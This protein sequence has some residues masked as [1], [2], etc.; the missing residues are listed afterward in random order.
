MA[1]VSHGKYL[2]CVKEL[3]KTLME[4]PLIR[5]LGVDE[6]LPG[7]LVSVRFLDRSF[8]SGVKFWLSFPSRF[9]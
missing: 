6:D 4:L 8:Q 3:Y 2:P 5:K 7:P 9:E 1:V